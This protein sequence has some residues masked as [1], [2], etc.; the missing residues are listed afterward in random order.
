MMVRSLCETLENAEEKWRD[1]S[2]EWKRK[3]EKVRIWQA[4]ERE[5][6]RRAERIRGAK[7]SSL[8]EEARTAD[9]RTWEST[10]DESKPSEEFS[11]IGSQVA[12]SVADL[13]KEIAALQW[14]SSTP[15][16]AYR[17][18]RRGIAVHHSGMNKGYRS[19]V[20]RYAH[21]ACLLDSMPK[22]PASLFRLRFL[23]VVIAT[24]ESS[25]LTVVSA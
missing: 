23:S 24:G 11:F 22:L 5:R 2:P 10:F 20:E 14:S 15:E 8:E 18:L 19:M 13:D 21:I 12:Y 9:D 16:W 17:A 7:K 4:G 3:L 25:L 6:Q 1:S